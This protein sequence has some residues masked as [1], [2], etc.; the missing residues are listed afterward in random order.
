MISNTYIEKQAGKKVHTFFL[1]LCTL[2]NLDPANARIV[3]NIVLEKAS[4]HLFNDQRYV[5][6]IPLQSFTDFFGVDYQEG[7]ADTL[8]V[9]LVKL[10]EENFMHIGQIHIVICET[11]K[12]LGAHLY[13]DTKYKKRIPTL[14]LVSQFISNE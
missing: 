12:E 2:E 14:E 11:K 5:K 3:I 4:V 10:C 8:Y 1:H 7:T 13:E 9:Y 6:T